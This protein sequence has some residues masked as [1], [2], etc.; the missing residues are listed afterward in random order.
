MVSGHE[1][2]ILCVSQHQY[3]IFNLS[4]SSLYVDWRNM[5]YVLSIHLT[6]L[7]CFSYIFQFLS[8]KVSRMILHK[9]YIIKSGQERIVGG[10]P[11]Q[12]YAWPWQV[13]LFLDNNRF[14][15]GTIISHDWI[16]TAAHCLD[17]YVTVEC[18]LDIANHLIYLKLFYVKKSL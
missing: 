11:A 13:A 14:C 7:K 6:Y 12:P 17:G 10:I 1:N 16:V 5:Q 8:S 2:L 9:K 3:H 15:G 4:S 18:V